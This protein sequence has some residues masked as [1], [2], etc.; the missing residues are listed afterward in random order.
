[1]KSES[2]NGGEAELDGIPQ[3]R[4][5]ASG[6]LNVTGSCCRREQDE[7]PAR[8]AACDSFDMRQAGEHLV[9]TGAAKPTDQGELVRNLEGIREERGDPGGSFRS[10]RGFDRRRAFK[11]R[12]PRFPDFSSSFITELRGRLSCRQL[13]PPPVGVFQSTV[14]MWGSCFHPTCCCMCTRL[15]RVHLTA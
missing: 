4:S 7:V 15:D 5:E 6:K 2:K 14:W 8:S 10:H 3:G 11:L 13:T 1:M 9:Q 12:A